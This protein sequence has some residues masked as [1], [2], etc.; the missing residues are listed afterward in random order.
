MISLLPPGAKIWPKM[1]QQSE[2]W[3]RVRTGRATASQFKR[4]ITP[5]KGALAAGRFSYI[6][7]LIAECHAK[8]D[9]PSFSGTRFTDR[10]NELEPFARA[11]FSSDKGFQVDEVGF[12]T[13]ERWGHV[14]GG[15]PDG[16]ILSPDGTHYVGG[17]EIKCLSR[18]NH[19]AIWDEG[20]MPDEYKAQVHGGMAVTGL[21]YWWF[22]SY[23][24]AMEP[25]YQKIEWDDYT[26]KLVECLD[27]FLGEYAQK[28]EVLNPK[29]K[30]RR[31]E[32]AL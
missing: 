32:Q 8:E 25:F 22:M 19:V 11:E 17:L 18:D 24:P 6:V 27:I 28:R 3:Y 16:L 5:A 13:N 10:G 12:V 23:H 30:R 26:D 31:R 15:S 7:D 4:I 20:L 9:L 14:V 21:P 2:E 29:L 1:Q